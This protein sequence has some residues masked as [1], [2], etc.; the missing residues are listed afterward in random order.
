MP[1][2]DYIR[3]FFDSVQPA[4]RIS[5]SSLI[6][7]CYVALGY[8]TDNNFA[9]AE[10]STHLLAILSISRPPYRNQTRE[11]AARDN[12]TACPAIALFEAK[13]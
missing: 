13:P 11:E 12:S 9:S 10:H 2:L 3:S 7:A 4:E 1:P 5:L 8:R 6:Q